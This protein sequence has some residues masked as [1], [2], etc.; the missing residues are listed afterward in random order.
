MTAKYRAPPVNMTP[1]AKIIPSG[2]DPDEDK[3]P[4]ANVMVRCRGCRRM[5]TVRKALH[6]G[7]KLPEG[8]VGSSWACRECLAEATR[9]A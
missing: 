6:I 7:H 8:D 4:S 3:K 9:A 5:L 2:I 1:R